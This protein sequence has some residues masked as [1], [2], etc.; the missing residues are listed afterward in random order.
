MSF[1]IKVVCWLGF[2]A[3]SLFMVHPSWAEESKSVDTLPQ[4]LGGV[5]KS[6]KEILASV[7]DTEFQ[8]V[9]PT[10]EPATLTLDS[11]RRGQVAWRE[12]LKSVHVDYTYLLDRRSSTSRDAQLDP[13][14]A[15]PDGFTGDFL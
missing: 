14:Q 2:G 7:Q 8:R 10:E 3:C 5:R 13:E 11:L 9:E 12:A 15:N 1:R 4:G 6:Y